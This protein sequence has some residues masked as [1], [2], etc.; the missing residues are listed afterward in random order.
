MP[1]ALERTGATAPVRA[2]HFAAEATDAALASR[3]SCDDRAAAAQLIGVG[4]VLDA[5]ARTSLGAPRRELR[6]L[7]E[8]ARHFE[9]ATRSHVRAKDA[10]MY[11]LRR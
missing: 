9:R 3:T 10:E 7:R 5:L 11:A 8:A 6:E 1:A 4:E 2:R